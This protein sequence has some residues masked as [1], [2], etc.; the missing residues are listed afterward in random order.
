V[1]RHPVVSVATGPAYPGL[2]SRDVEADLLAA[3][4][5]P[6][7][8]PDFDCTGVNSTSYFEPAL[9]HHPFA[10]FINPRHRQR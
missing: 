1:D 6:A 7:R 10:K 8:P 2:K 4:K 5:S 3:I 9:K